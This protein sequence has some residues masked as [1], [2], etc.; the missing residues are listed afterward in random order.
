MLLLDPSVNN[1]SAIIILGFPG[2][3][4]VKNLLANA[5]DT[6]TQ[7]CSLG[8]EDPLEEE[9]ETHSSIL[10]WEIPWAEELQSIESQRVGHD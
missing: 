5:G 10:A 7:V 9:M 3:A 1:N 4:V 8:R 2:G 6:E